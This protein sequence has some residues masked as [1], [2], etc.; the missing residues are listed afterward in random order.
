MKTLT[1]AYVVLLAES[2][3]LI[4]VS[5]FMFVKP[6]TAISYIGKFAST[7]LINYS[8]LIIR[9]I[10]G[11]AF[12][13]YADFSRYPKVFQVIGWFLT[14]S[15]IIIMV[16]PRRWHASYAKYWSEK[17]PPVFMRIA[18]PFSLLAGAL[19]VYVVN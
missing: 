11:I 17:L 14:V 2:V 5:V 6:Q 19:L 1:F 12:I 16:L 15:A 8:E 7:N 18:A 4:G 13:V 10:V 3:W 9:L